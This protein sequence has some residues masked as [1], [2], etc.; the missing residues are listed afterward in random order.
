MDSRE[1]RADLISILVLSQEDNTDIEAIHA[2]I[3]RELTV[4]STQT[5][6]MD[7][8]ELS[9]RH[10]LRCGRR[11]SDSYGVKLHCDVGIAAAV[12]GESDD[13]EPDTKRAKKHMYAGAYRQYVSATTSGSTAGCAVKGT[14]ALFAALPPD[15]RARYE[16]AADC[17]KEA[18]RVGGQGFH[19]NKKARDM[20]A[21]RARNRDIANAAKREREVDPDNTSASRA[22]CALHLEDG[23]SFDD[24]VRAI[25]RGLRDISTADKVGF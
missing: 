11:A 15:E 16:L 13:T 20:E 22:F 8:G 24:G 10:V 6:T 12:G 18:I 9:D 19:N 3:R 25:K 1:A 2:S 21:R 4:L 7:F 23:T 5:K 17:A 14:G